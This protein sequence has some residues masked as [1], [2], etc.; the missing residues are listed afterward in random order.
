MWRKRE[1]NPWKGAVAGMLGGLAASFVMN[2]FQAAPSKM[3]SS[4]EEEH[5][6]EGSERERGAGQQ[7]QRS[8]EPATVKTATAVSQAVLERE[9]KPE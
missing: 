9:L 4:R 5:A 1:P 2:Q 8:E 6:E 7:A 3:K